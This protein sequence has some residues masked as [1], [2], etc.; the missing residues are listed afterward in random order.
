MI[1]LIKVSKEFRFVGR[2]SHIQGWTPT[3][4]ALLGST[5]T[6]WERGIG[7]SKST[8]GSNESSMQFTLL[9]TDFTNDAIE[10][11]VVVANDATMAKIHSF[12]VEFSDGVGTLTG[13]FLPQL[14]GG[15]IRTYTTS[16]MD[17]TNVGGAD[18]TAITSL[19]VRVVSNNNADTWATNE[20]FIRYV[21]RNDTAII[22]NPELSVEWEQKLSDTGEGK[23]ELPVSDL[24]TQRIQ[25]WDKVEI[26]G[27]E[28]GIETLLT[29]GVVSTIT[30]T[31]LIC[32]IT[33][34]TEQ[35]RLQRL[36][37]PEDRVYTAQTLEF[38]VNALFI[39]GT[40]NSLL[41]RTSLNIYWYVSTSV[42]STVVDEIK[43]SYG[44]S[45]FDMIRQLCEV[46]S[47]YWQFQKNR[48]VISDVIGQD[49]S[50]GVNQVQ[51]RFN[52]LNPVESNIN[53]FEVR[54]EGNEIITRIYAKNDNGTDIEESN[55]PV[56]GD[57]ESFYS[58]PDGDTQAHAI[59][60]VTERSTQHKKFVI[61]I[62]PEIPLQSVM[63]GDII[64]L[65]IE[66]TNTRL[67]TDIPVL[68]E[69]KRGIFQNAKILY[70][71]TL[72]DGFYTT[73][74]FTQL[75]Q[76]LQRRTTRLEITS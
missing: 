45:Y 4:G 34:I 13:V 5:G 74:S 20:V 21:K 19:R 3:G 57:I 58:V 64:R 17:F 52:E 8:T 59:E 6:E 67:Q 11:A 61:D 65:T 55:V 69:S 42:A 71:I 23:F 48:L 44:D 25:E 62:G 31:N 10:L 32:S 18:I 27:L 30:F 38:I 40:S 33:F 43:F 54:H 46:T 75:L 35:R 63:V 2:W 28:S 1:P 39:A 7:L 56:F 15:E 68:V 29:T 14:I 50:S 22:L 70:T 24:R 16:L 47:L 12:E 37:L 60:V 26:Y 73:K 53:S 41:N 49:K 51:L 36:V 66:H 76:D 72:Q 9:P